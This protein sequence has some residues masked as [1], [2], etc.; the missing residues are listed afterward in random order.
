M[1]LEIRRYDPADRDAVDAVVEAA[2]RDANAYFEGVPALEDGDIVAE[3]V[4]AGGEFLVGSLDGEVVATAAFRPPNGVVAEQLPVDDRTAE[5]KRMH[6]RPD[7]HREGIGAA[8]YEA[9]ETRARERGY[10]RLVLSTTG[11]QTAAHAFYEERGFERVA[12]TTESV[13]ETELSIL[14]FEKGLD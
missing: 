2:L 9:I 3:Y 11:R 14:V 8:I 10:G 6:V 4:D 12:G 13:A 5:L 7:H 1:T